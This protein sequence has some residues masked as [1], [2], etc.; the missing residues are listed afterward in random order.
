[1]RTCLS[2][3]IPVARSLPSNPLN[4]KLPVPQPRRRRLHHGHAGIPHSPRDARRLRVP[5][6]NAALRCWSLRCPCCL[7]QS[8]LPRHLSSPAFTSPLNRGLKFLCQ[9]LHPL[10]LCIGLVLYRHGFTQVPPPRQF[11]RLAFNPSRNGPNSRKQRQP[12]LLLLL[13]LLPV[14]LFSSVW[15]TTRSW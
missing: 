15:P 12:L 8:L 6:S 2:P 7:Q 5:Q 13:P 1:M 4:V 10:L 14:Q 3:L 11:S 9:I